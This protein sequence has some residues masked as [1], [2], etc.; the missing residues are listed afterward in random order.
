MIIKKIQKWISHDQVMDK[1]HFLFVLIKVLVF[2][3]SDYCKTS[4]MLLKEK[5][6]HGF[7]LK[8]KILLLAKEFVS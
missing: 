8:L 5:D 6:Q 1:V 4:G 3:T 7:K 2:I